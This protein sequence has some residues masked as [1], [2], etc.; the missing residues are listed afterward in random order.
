MIHALHIL[1]RICHHSQEYSEKLISLGCTKLFSIALVHSLDPTVKKMAAWCIGQAGCKS[2]E[3][4]KIV[5][6]QGGL[7]AIIKSQSC[8]DSDEQ[9]SHTCKEAA[10]NVIS[11]LEYLAALIA[12]LKIDVC[13]HIKSAL[14]ER[15]CKI[16]IGCP[17]SRLEFVQTGGLE[18]FFKHGE[19]EPSLS[20]YIQEISSLYPTEIVDRCSPEYMRRLLEKFKR[21]SLSAENKIDG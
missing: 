3:A 15:L 12:L 17:S 4:A 10:V 7:L 8:D 2:P 6:E 21:E 18:A 1:G 14:F 20:R 13:M 5:T 11:S 16:L 9:L 19:T